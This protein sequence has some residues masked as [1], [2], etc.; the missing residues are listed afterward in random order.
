MHRR[1]G[2]ADGEP[3]GLVDHLGG[4]VLQSSLVLLGVMGAKEQLATG[5][6]PDQD[7][8]LSTAAV[9]AVGGG[10]RAAW[11]NG[12]GHGASLPVRWPWRVG[13]LS[14]R[15]NIPPQRKRSRWVVRARFA[16]GVVH[17]DGPLVDVTHDTPNCHPVATV[18]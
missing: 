11:S 18:P 13:G 5:Q 8:R 15:Y 7:V 12:S 10:Q 6:Q 4:D 2:S 16:F 3:L 9:A 14:Y 17:L 1:L